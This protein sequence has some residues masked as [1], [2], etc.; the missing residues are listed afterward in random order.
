VVTVLG[1]RL[2]LVRVLEFIEKIVAAGLNLEA[3]HFQPPAG[4]A[5]HRYGGGGEGQLSEPGAIP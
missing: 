2:S 5:V 1:N 3:M 4:V